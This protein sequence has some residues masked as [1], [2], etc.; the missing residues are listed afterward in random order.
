[1][2]S[3]QSQWTSFLAEFVK[4]QAS[5][6][7]SKSQD[8]SVTR[9]MQGW[10]RMMMSSMAISPWYPRPAYALNTICLTQNRPVNGIN[11]IN[12]HLNSIF[13]CEVFCMHHMNILAEFIRGG[14]LGEGG[15]SLIMHYK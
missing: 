8:V 13:L 14:D 10:G 12:K 5:G 4:P 6:P 3:Y 1:M 2:A 7:N 15:G 11:F 9:S